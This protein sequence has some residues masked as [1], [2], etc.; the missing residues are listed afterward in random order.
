LAAEAKI[1]NFGTHP[2]NNSGMHAKE[3]ICTVLENIWLTPT[4]LRIRFETLKRLTFRPGQFVSVL[5]PDEDT[6]ETIK[7][8]YSFASS[9]L[10]AEELGYFELCIRYVPGGLGSSYVA[11]LRKGDT[12][13]IL[14]PYGD[15]RYRSP[16]PGRGVCFICT[17]TGL[18]P[19]RSMIFSAEFQ[20]NPPAHSICLLGVRNERELLYRGDLERAGVDAVYAVSDGQAP[21][22]TFQG[23][24]TDVLK[25]L[26]SNWKWHSTDFYIC[27]N[28]EMVK[29]VD[30][31]L[32][33]GHGVAES[34][35]HKEAFSLV[36]NPNAAAAPTNQIARKKPESS[37]LSLIMPPIKDAA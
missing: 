30:H 6:G 21:P 37:L 25:R 17:G 24:V 13:R 36:T 22:S 29:D 7:R 11:A 4:V 27:G 15:F 10:E 19:F 20:Q 31:L 3:Q 14:A 9:P 32:R 34:A 8:C 5:V 1:A 35:I 28:G 26:P 12:F 23:R 33:G 16:E 2:A 18:A